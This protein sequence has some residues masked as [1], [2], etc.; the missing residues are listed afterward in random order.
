MAISESYNIKE[1]ETT[2][3]EDAEMQGEVAFSQNGHDGAQEDSSRLKEFSQKV[4][5]YIL[6]QMER[7]KRVLY[8]KK[9]SFDNE[10]E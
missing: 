10:T 6:E 5:F 1:K 2:F 8:K 7:N 3:A 9:M 4:P